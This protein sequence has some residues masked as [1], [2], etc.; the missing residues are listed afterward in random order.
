MRFPRMEILHA[1]HAPLAALL[2]ATLASTPVSASITVAPQK[3]SV[4]SD[5]VHMAYATRWDEAI[6]QSR[7]GNTLGALIAME[8]LM[9]DPLLDDFD[10][11]R[12]AAP[13]RWPAGPHWCRRSRP[14]PAVICSGRWKRCPTIRRSCSP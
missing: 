12:R 5:A 7:S 14:R 9:E 6:Q 1:P 11:E 4:T 13:R 3:P 8:Q 2:I 10:A